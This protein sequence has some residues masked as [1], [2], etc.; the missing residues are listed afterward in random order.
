MLSCICVYVHK[1]FTGTPI[2]ATLSFCPLTE[3]LTNRL[4]RV[5]YHAA[6]FVTDKSVN[7]V[8]SIFKLGWPPMRERRDWHLLK[9]VHKAL[10]SNTWP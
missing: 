4:Q 8:D 2:L 10:Y 7:S 6:S 1:P 9:T 5:Q 3:R